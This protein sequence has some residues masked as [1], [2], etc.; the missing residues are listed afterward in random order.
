MFYKIGI[1]DLDSPRTRQHLT[2]TWEKTGSGNGLSETCQPIDKIRR[3]ITENNPKLK[4]NEIIF[5]K[6]E[7]NLFIQGLPA[8]EGT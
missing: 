4:Y 8:T 1:H 2:T 6:Q 3:N 7:P 5:L